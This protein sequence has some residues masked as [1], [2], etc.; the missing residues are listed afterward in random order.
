MEGGRSATERS[1]GVLKANCISASSSTRPP[2]VGRRRADVVEPVVGEAPAA[3]AGKA[4]GLAGKER[5]AAL[6]R[7]RDRR[8]VALDPGVERRR[9]GLERAL[10]GGDRRD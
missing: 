10:E 3:M 7:R 6:C 8:L 4:V 2:R 1:V 5:E 9:A